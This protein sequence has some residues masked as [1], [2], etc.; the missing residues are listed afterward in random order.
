MPAFNEITPA[1]L[2]RLIGT[3]D[4]PPLFDLRIEADFEDDPRVLPGAM[5]HS[6]SDP[7]G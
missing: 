7:E 1:K 6:H 3:P 2:N 5:R 4:L